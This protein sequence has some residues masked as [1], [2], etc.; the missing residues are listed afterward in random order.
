MVLC[1]VVFFNGQSWGSSALLRE[2]PVVTSSGP[3][4]NYPWITATKTEM[5]LR[6]NYR[7]NCGN[8]PRF[9]P[10]SP[11]ASDFRS[12]YPISSSVYR[13]IMA[14][15][16]WAVRRIEGGTYAKC[17]EWHLT[18]SECSVS[19]SFALFSLMG[20]IFKIWNIVIDA[21]TCLDTLGLYYICLCHHIKIL[22]LST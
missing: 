21:N 10:Q 7:C 11:E 15:S 8:H 17:S 20:C 22:C 19:I 14:L 4:L 1:F 18:H 9:L 2:H 5:K 13:A 12:A 3:Y 16:T 6:V